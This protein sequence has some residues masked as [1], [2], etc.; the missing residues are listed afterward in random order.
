MIII[1]IKAIGSDK[2]FKV[3]C[4]GEENSIRFIKSIISSHYKKID[5]DKIIL[6]YESQILNDSDTV[7]S[8]GLN[9]NT[10]LILGFK[11]NTGIYTVL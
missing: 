2:I 3:I 5:T 7:G 4:M 11:M 10:I 1:P 8:I 6:M 9:E